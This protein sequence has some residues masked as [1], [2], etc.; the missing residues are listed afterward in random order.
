MDP[1]PHDHAGEPVAAIGPAGCP[2]SWLGAHHARHE[3][4]T[5][6]VVV[7]TAA[8]MVGEII[9]GTIFGSM[10]LV[11]DGWHMATHTAALGIATLAYRYARQHA[12]DPSFAFGTG[13]VGELAGFASAI[14]LGLVS[15]LIAWESIHR[16]L[17]PRP[18]DFLQAGAIAVLGL[19]VNLVSAVL[20]RHDHHHDH[21]HEHEHEHG[22]GHGHEHEHDDD[23]DDHHHEHDEHDDHHHDTNLRAAYL[24]VIADAFTSVLAIAGLL[25]GAYLGWTWM[26]A[27][28]GIIGAI[29]IGHWSLGLSRAAARSLLD[30]HNDSRLRKAVQTRI[31]ADGHA[32]VQDLHLWRLGPEHHGLLL[33][34]RSTAPQLQSPEH[35]KRLLADLPSL[36]HV[37][38]E[39]N[40]A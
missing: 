13:K 12:A 15:V 39:V 4:R 36:G 19:L 33:S 29:V 30:A 26:D 8:M 25:A 9:G 35:Y 38:V 21:G 18:I 20:L 16:L 6:W 31:A 37:T 7:L 17:N 28:I 32:T 11:A 40:P 23:D 22:H 27:S 34:L 3:R 10:A 1:H 2:Q 14:S 24:H 5:L